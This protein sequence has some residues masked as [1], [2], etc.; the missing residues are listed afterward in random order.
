[1]NAVLLR[2]TR[3]EDDDDEFCRFSRIRRWRI[4]FR[5]LIGRTE[6]N[7]NSISKCL[8]KA[9]DT[10]REVFK[11]PITTLRLAHK[12]INAL[13]LR[14]QKL[15]ISI[16]PMVPTARQFISRFV[17]ARRAILCFEHSIQLI[18][19][20]MLDFSYIFSV[21]RVRANNSGKGV[22]ACDSHCPCY[23]SRR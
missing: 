14:Q 1:M 4:S 23:S 15:S 20:L 10:W 3:P 17:I 16:Q 22:I 13:H 19:D 11:V 18:C 21:A 12:Y 2:I 6:L 7:R 5:I 8:D 9:L